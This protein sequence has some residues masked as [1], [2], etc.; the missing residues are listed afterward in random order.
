LIK[1]TGNRI[2]ITG[3]DLFCDKLL[4]INKLTV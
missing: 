3:G 1:A 2:I 4:F